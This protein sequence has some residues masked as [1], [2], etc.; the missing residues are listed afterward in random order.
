[1]AWEGDVETDM[2]S[3]P[4][5]WIPANAIARNPVYWFSPNSLCR[6]CVY[7]FLQEPLC[8]IVNRQKGESGIVSCDGYELETQIDTRNPL[9][10]YTD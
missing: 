4:A 7:Q 5:F 1:M 3:K 10:S 8:Q 2:K 6:T 9:P